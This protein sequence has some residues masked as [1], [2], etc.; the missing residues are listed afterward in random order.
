[1]LEVAIIKHLK[2]GFISITALLV[3]GCGSLVPSSSSDEISSSYFDSSLTSSSEYIYPTPAARINKKIATVTHFPYIPSNYEYFDYRSAAIELDDVVFNFANN[4][5]VVLPSY[6]ST[7]PSSWQ[8]IGYWLDQ[9]RQPPVYDPLETGYLKRTFGLPTYVG[10]N[11]VISS[12]S[13]AMTTIASV[14]GS[15]FLGIDKQSQMFG[16]DE[17]DF[18][19][20]TFA[21]YDTGSKLV[22]NY[23]IQ[24]QSFWYDLFPQ[25]IFTRLYDLYQSTPFMREMVLNGADEWLEALPYFQT[26]GQPDFEFVGFNVV[27]ESPTLTG[28]HIEPPNGGLAFIFYAA[29]EM[30]KEEKYLDGAK[31]VLDYLQTYQKNPNYEALTDYAP[32]VAAILNAKYETNYDV[33]KFLD[34]IFD[35]DSAFRPGWAVMNSNLGGFPAHGLVGQSGDYAFAMN[36]FHLATTLAPLVKYDVRYADAI[37]QYLL[38]LV[39]NARVFF[40]HTHDLSHQS[41]NRYLP[42]DLKGS[43]VYEGFRNYYNSTTG[44]AMGDATTM[45]GQPSDLSLYSSA[46][47]GGLGSI[48]SPTNIEAILKIDLNKTDSFGRNDFPHYLLFNPYED[49][50]IIR[51]DGPETSYDLF[52]LSS[53]SFIARNVSGSINIRLPARGS[54]VAAELPG[55]SFPVLEDDQY[56]VGEV[57]LVR[58]TVAVNLTNIV[59]RQQL[60]SSSAINIETLTPADDEVVNMTISFNDIIVYDGVPVMVFHYDKNMLPNTDYTLKIEI[61]SEK[62][63]RDYVTKRVVCL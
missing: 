62:G 56:F 38:N 34:F 14:L 29:Y 55:N 51:Y 53:Q 17:Y 16:S 44:Y 2:Y 52:D 33:G 49:N 35:G 37:G 28:G 21:S 61:T 8:P 23:G 57:P 41:M 7:D 54:L 26:N 39:N 25:I 30:T 60:T 15:S 9:P 4:P 46:F 3:G 12:G 45:F 36:S 47:I 10:D 48:V 22:H 1:M 63:H 11:R 32:Y 5:N 43:L 27:L 20:M 58:K 40:P 6:I 19:E 31:E 13:E 59:T 18:V 24:G 50:R 42:F